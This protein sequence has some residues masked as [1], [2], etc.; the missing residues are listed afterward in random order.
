MRDRELY[1]RILGVEAPW[2]VVEVELSDDQVEVTVE[3]SGKRLQCPTCKAKASKHDARKR[4]WRHLDTCQLKTIIT[5]DVPRVSCE[6]HGVHQID[7]PWAEP[8]SGFTA[9]F[10]C[11]VIDWLGEASIKAVAERLRCTWDQVD[12]IRDRA[13][14][15]GLARRESEGAIAVEH[16]AVDETSFQKRHEYVTIVSDVV[17]DRVLYVADGRGRES[18]GDFFWD[19]PLEHVLS[20]ESIAMDMWRPYI[21]A[22]MGHIEGAESKICFDRFHVAAHLNKAV[23]DVRRAEHRALKEA[24]DDRLA[25]TRYLWLKNEDNLSESQR[26][27]FDELK[28]QALE[29]AKAWAIKEAARGLWSYT[30]RG[31]ARRAWTK[32][33]AWMRT[34]ALAPME[35]VASLIERHL[36]GI[37]NAIVLGRSNGKAESINSRV[38]MLKKRACGFRNRERYRSA[39]YFHLGG[40]DLKPRLA[41]A[42]TKS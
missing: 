27:R 24:G 34:T 6:E 42:H 3:H 32:L 10:E 12:G 35:K 37:L 7:V 9:M 11:L 40:L 18:L 41:Q 20:V 8:R 16:L 30:K 14:A 5:A 36:E 31:W 26:S 2:R 17:G 21:E 29:V 28:G 22:A 39:I 15:R 19:M 13:V 4:S 1:A 25:R 33:I 23:N 38:Q